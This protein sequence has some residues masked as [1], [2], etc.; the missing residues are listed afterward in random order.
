MSPL[1]VSSPRSFFD[2]GPSAPALFLLMATLLVAFWGPGTARAM[3]GAD[4]VITALNQNIDDT[5]AGFQEDNFD[6]FEQNLKLLKANL[7]NAAYVATSIV[8]ERQTNPAYVPVALKPIP[9]ELTPAYYEEMVPKQEE[10]LKELA[11]SLV[12]SEKALKKQQYKGSMTVLLAAIQTYLDAVG[13][14]SKNPLTVV[15][16]AKDTLENSKK[17]AT[18]ISN[19]VKAQNDI[20]TTIKVLQEEHAKLTKQL[21]DSKVQWEKVNQLWPIFEA[22]WIHHQTVTSYIATGTAL[23][24]PAPPQPEFFATGYVNQ[25][26]K[27]EEALSQGKI[28]W[29]EAQD[30]GNK[31]QDEAQDDYSAIASPT[32]DDKSEWAV[33]QAAWAGFL[34]GLKAQRAADV[35]TAQQLGEEWRTALIAALQPWVALDFGERL[36][37]YDCWDEQIVAI[38]LDLAA[39]TSSWPITDPAEQMAAVQFVLTQIEGPWVEPESAEYGGAAYL[40]QLAAYPAR[41]LELLQDYEQSVHWH[42]A[43]VDRNTWTAWQSDSCLHDPREPFAVTPLPRW[44]MSCVM[45]NLDLVGAEAAR[46]YKEFIAAPE[47][48]STLQAQLDAASAKAQAYRDFLV[49]HPYTVPE[50][51]FMEA[52]VV[53]A[54]DVP[55]IVA[56]L[57]FAQDGISPLEMSAL[58]VHLEMAQEFFALEAEVL[59]FAT[60]EVAERATEIW[61][62]L[63]ETLKFNDGLKGALQEVDDMEQYRAVKATCEGLTAGDPAAMWNALHMLD[64]YAYQVLEGSAG[65]TAETHVWPYLS[66]VL[67]LPQTTLDHFADLAEETWVVTDGLANVSYAGN[68]GWTQ[69]IGA[70]FDCA[71]PSTLTRHL[72]LPDNEDTAE[73]ITAV[74]F[75]T[76]SCRP[77]TQ[78][79]GFVTMDQLRQGLPLMQAWV[80]IEFNGGGSNLQLEK[81]MGDGIKVAQGTVSGHP[82]V[83]RALTL[84]GK[85]VGGAVVWTESGPPVVTNSLGQAAF[86]PGPFPVPGGQQIVVGLAGGQSVSFTIQVMVDTD[87]DGAYDEWEEANGLDP[88]FPLDAQF[89]TDLDGLD[90]SAECAYGTNPDQADSDGDGFPDGEEV[91]AGVSPIDP[92]TDPE[93]PPLDPVVPGPVEGPKE[94]FGTQ[95]EWSAVSPGDTMPN[96]AFDGQI[97]SL[98]IMTVARFDEEN[99]APGMNCY[100]GY[101]YEKDETGAAIYR[102]GRLITHRFFACSKYAAKVSIDGFNFTD[103]EPPEPPWE[104][105][106]AAPI[107]AHEG[108]LWMLGGHFRILRPDFYDFL[109]ATTNCPD[110]EGNPQECPATIPTI[111]GEHRDVWVSDDGV[112]WEMVIAQAPW[113]RASAVFSHNG[114]LWNVDS[115]SGEVWISPNGADWTLATNS[116]QWA[117]RVYPQLVSHDGKVWLMG[118]YTS[119]PCDDCLEPYPYYEGL[120]NYFNDVWVTSD[121]IDWTLV[122][123]HA[124]WSPRALYKTIATGG[125]MWA[126]GYPVCSPKALLCPLP[127][128]WSSEAGD[129]WEMVMVD[130]LLYGTV[131]NWR[132]RLWIY[133]VEYSYHPAVPSTGAEVYYSRVADGEACDEDSDCDGIPDAQDSCPFAYSP[134]P[135]DT[136][137][138]GLFDACDLDDDGDGIDDEDDNCRI[139]PNPLQVDAEGDGVGDLCDNCLQASNKDQ[140]D[141]DGDGFGDAC[142]IWSAVRGTVYYDGPASGELRIVADFNELNVLNL[143]HQLLRRDES[144]AVYDWLPD[145]G[146][147]EYSLIV[148]H[149]RSVRAIFAYIDVDGNGFADPDEPQ[150]WHDVAF[151]GPTTDDPEP[152]DIALSDAG[153]GG[154]GGGCGCRLSQRGQAPSAGAGI[155]M[156]L[157]AM[158]LATLRRC[159]RTGLRIT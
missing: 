140:S 158:L 156:L 13:A 108:R 11:A 1:H 31:V 67:S 112:N 115:S 48:L 135:V 45:D 46:F 123:D 85:P 59:D 71:M 90:A 107:L 72:V 81:I 29:A 28:S 65:T 79:L 3:D 139:V 101:E 147:Q 12:A 93:T 84:S 152:R 14:V 40:Q 94:P 26:D 102:D 116:P 10:H 60:D 58:A 153:M 149:G 17:N 120:H 52:V 22:V 157:V 154:S 53:T 78:R 16:G 127:Q 34:S 131:L 134:V 27:L 15:T 95:W 43:S 63:E 98:R 38:P 76:T 6:K 122:V 159:S 39:K 47:K 30:L 73:A 70:C 124:P 55:G 64:N 117:P 143:P 44:T 132:S 88:D 23:P 145:Q 138:D 151:V 142:D 97:Y 69:T 106:S 4:G 87:G 35:A 86:Y 8:Q 20:K 36:E 7:T 83:V 91:N 24:V 37:L 89:D 155:L 77:Y 96:V 82:L 99:I 18:Y 74:R 118:G 2:L 141:D 111:E 105:R 92:E 113:V 21:K 144:Q 61:Y 32:T 128:L 125:R 42:R 130:D 121:G 33:F 56:R 114:Q 68:P 104:P 146:A 126:F 5:Y 49:S 150:G 110:L 66:Y 75:P 51:E 50:A 9:K 148:E 19:Q 57:P 41:L 119:E 137:Q 62:D 100:A 103:L 136:D 109:D 80:N 25:L 133:G 129:E 54:A